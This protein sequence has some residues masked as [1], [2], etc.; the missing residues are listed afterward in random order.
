MCWLKEG[1][2]I[3]MSKRRKKIIIVWFIGGVLCIFVF[4][5]LEK[6]YLGWIIG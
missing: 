6:M 4:L 3:K 1:K 5:L 2:N